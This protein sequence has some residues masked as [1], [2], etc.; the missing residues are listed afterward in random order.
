MA[1]P[2]EILN[3]PSSLSQSDWEFIR[4]HTILG[5]RILDG[6]PALRGVARLVRASH[7]CWDGSGYPDKLR[8]EA[9]PL[10]ARIVS[11]CDAYDAM[12]SERAYRGAIPHETAC[13]ELR[14]CS[15]KQFDPDVV[16]A[17][18]KIASTP[19]REPEL[20]SAQGA[21]VHVRNFLGATAQ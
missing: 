17:F 7:E 2:D 15:G 6:A 13:R 1:I 14:R 10:G 3:K 16:S 21:A 4:N 20:D 19:D 18:L 9:I 8:G 11:V 12:T 5:E